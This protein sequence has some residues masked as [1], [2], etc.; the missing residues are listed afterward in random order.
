MQ[1]AE[2][3]KMGRLVDIDPFLLEVRSQL[4]RV[5]TCDEN[6]PPNQLELVDMMVVRLR[7]HDPVAS[8]KA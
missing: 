1:I 3:E 2:C 8:L 4:S 5:K 6:K 7:S